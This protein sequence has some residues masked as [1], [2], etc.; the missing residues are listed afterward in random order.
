MNAQLAQRLPASAALVEDPHRRAEPILSGIRQCTV[1][2]ERET[3]EIHRLGVF[4]GWTIE[5]VELNAG[6]Y[7]PPHVHQRAQARL[8]VVVGTG[9]IM[10]GGLAHAYRAGDVFTVLAGVSHGFRVN[11]QT[12]LLSSQ[13][14]PILDIETGEIDLRYV[15]SQRS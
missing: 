9:T 3:L 13:D 6:Q 12:V 5:L 14:A 2:T 15:D 11:D 1:K 10:L 7:Y 4:D 8:Q